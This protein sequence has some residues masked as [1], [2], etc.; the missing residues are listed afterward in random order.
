VKSVTIYDPE[1]VTVQDLG[2]QVSSLALHGITETEP[3][4]FFLRESDIG[5]PRAAVTVPRL[6][7]LNAYVPVK[8]LGGRAGQSLTPDLISGFQVRA[9]SA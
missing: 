8:D 3:S 1:P 2:T 4:Q 5:K 9:L 7:E 6:A